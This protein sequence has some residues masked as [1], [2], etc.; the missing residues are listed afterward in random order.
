MLAP[1]LPPLRSARLLDQLRAR[2]RFLHCSR[3]TEGAYVYRC[4]AFMRF[5]R[6]QRPPELEAKHAVESFLSWLADDRG[7][8]A[9]THRQAL[10]A[11]LFL[12]G[13]VARSG[14]PRAACSPV[15]A[16]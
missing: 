5:H 8:A 6:L 14:R 16:L 10:S 12:H 13:K 9:S 2:I 1:S 4:R 15:N 3:R 7:V 11:L